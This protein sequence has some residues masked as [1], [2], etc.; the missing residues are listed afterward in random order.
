MPSESVESY[1]LL[2]LLAFSSPQSEQEAFIGWQMVFICLEY[3]HAVFGPDKFNATAMHTQF[4]SDQA[5]TV[6]LNHTAKMAC[7]VVVVIGF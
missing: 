2:W 4:I 5:Q 3:Y 7:V 1:H 6:L